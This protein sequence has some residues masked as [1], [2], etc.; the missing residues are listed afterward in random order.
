MGLPLPD[1][2]TM[3][4]RM[5]RGL[6]GE[7]DEVRVIALGTAD[8]VVTFD[9]GRYRTGIPMV[10]VGEERDLV[11]VAQ[12]RR[13]VAGGLAEVGHHPAAVVGDRQPIERR[14]QLVLPSVSSWSPAR[15]S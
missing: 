1:L 2:S 4:G 5:L 9:I 15:A 6:A 14:R 8:A 12:Q 11:R 3:R 7:G 10:T 13:L